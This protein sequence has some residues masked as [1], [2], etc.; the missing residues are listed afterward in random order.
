MRGRPGLRG[1]VGRVGG[2]AAGPLVSPR[3]CL[4][5]RAPVNG[6]P[7]VAFGVAARSERHSWKRRGGGSRGALCSPRP[8][9]GPAKCPGTPPPCPGKGPLPRQRL[10]PGKRGD[11]LVRAAGWSEC[12]TELCARKGEKTLKGLCVLTAGSLSRLR[13]APKGAG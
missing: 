2:A 12:V 3:P 5:G 9:S 4:T 13:A 10:A 8:R 6:S 11:S 1:G 7:G